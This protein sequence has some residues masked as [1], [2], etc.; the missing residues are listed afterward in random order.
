LSICLLAEGQDQE[1]EDILKS[2]VNPD[3]EANFIKE[4]VAEIYQIANAFFSEGQS[5]ISRK[6]YNAVLPFEPRLHDVSRGHLGSQISW[7]PSLASDIEILKKRLEDTF[8][9]SEISDE[10]LPSI[11]RKIGSISSEDVEAIKGRKV[12]LVLRDRMHPSLKLRTCEFTRNFKV[13]AEAVGLEMRFFNADRFNFDRL[14]SD[15]ERVQALKELAAVIADFRPDAVIFDQL[16]SNLS[17]KRLTPQIYAGALTKL[18]EVFNFKLISI[19][20]DAYWPECLWAINYS[21]EFVDSVWLLSH[22]AYSKLEPAAQAKSS[23][24]P[25]PYVYPRGEIDLDSKDVD[26]AF[27]GTTKR[28]NFLRSLWLL[29][30]ED[31][32]IPFELFLTDSQPKPNRLCLSDE[33][34]GALMGR[35]RTCIQFS[36]R[37][38]TT[39]ILCGRVW[40][41]MLVGCVLVEEENIETKE[42]LI[43]YLHYVPFNSLRELAVAV[44]CLERHPAVRE[45]LARR[46]HAWVQELLSGEKLWAYMLLKA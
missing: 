18:K 9:S 4:A 5:E 11:A 41:S 13:T 43:P 38:V 25:F 7:E 45:K 17:D 40:E 1:A 37:D 21:A 8:E 20:P 3:L 2:V 35:I 39:K 31:A 16:C 24:L 33:E 36:A 6:I 26:T 29:A 32:N 30:M 12:L 28:Y 42:L 34:Y 44:E 22:L 10:N 19:Y 23:V 27:L 46:G 14:Y 15:E